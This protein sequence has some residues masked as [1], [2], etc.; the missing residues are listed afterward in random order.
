MTALDRALAWMRGRC[1]AM[2]DG[3]RV[4]IESYPSTDMDTETGLPCT[5]ADTLVE[6][7]EGHAREAGD[8]HAALLLRA[9]EALKLTREAILFGD[10]S[11]MRSRVDGLAAI[12]DEM[13]GTK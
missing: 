11:L 6:M 13:R 7:I 10:K 9:D 3:Q 2:S 8:A 4:E 5:C 1:Q 12:L